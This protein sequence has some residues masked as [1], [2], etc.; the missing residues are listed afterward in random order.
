M[1]HDSMTV[2]L[3]KARDEPEPVSPAHIVSLKP[4]AQVR[5]PILPMRSGI[6]HEPDIRHDVERPT[7]A[8]TRPARSRVPRSLLALGGALLAIVALGM[9]LSRQSAASAADPDVDE[10]VAHV[11]TLI[12]LPQGEV[13]TVATVTDLSA[14]KGL[15]FFEHASQ[16]DKVLMYPKAQEAVLYDPQQ[17]KVIQVGPLTVSPSR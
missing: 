5:E 17:D 14:L 12:L 3:E 15:P 11:G 10:L 8:P 13:P 6:A 9:Y 7:N 1:T 2:K 16:G 4:K